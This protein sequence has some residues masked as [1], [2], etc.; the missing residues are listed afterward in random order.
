M[1]ILIYWENALL[2]GSTVSTQKNEEKTK[3]MSHHLKAEQIQN[4]ARR[5]AGIKTSENP[6]QFKHLCTVLTN[7]NCI[8]KVISS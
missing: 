7:Q 6:P 4:T 1:L 3:Y 2:G 5:W 8:Q